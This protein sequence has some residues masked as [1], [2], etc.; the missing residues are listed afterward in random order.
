M[1][2]YDFARELEAAF[3]SVGASVMS[4]DFAAKL[5]A[6]VFVMGGGNEAV[7]MNAKLNVG[8]AIAQQKFNLYGGE[9]PSAQDVGLIKRYVAELEKNGKETAWLGEIFERY[10]FKF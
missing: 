8:I 9:A 6:Y 5:L 1:T 2:E 3:N 7:T 4:A 10:D